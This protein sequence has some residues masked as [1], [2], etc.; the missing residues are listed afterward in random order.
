VR[1]MWDRDWRLQPAGETLE[2]Y[3]RI[4]VRSH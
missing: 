1:D 4:S 2:H 3:R